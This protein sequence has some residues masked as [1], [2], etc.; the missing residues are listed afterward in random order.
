LL[1]DDKDSPGRLDIWGDTVNV[2]C[3]QELAAPG[4]A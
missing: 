2:A 1:S 4:D 3:L